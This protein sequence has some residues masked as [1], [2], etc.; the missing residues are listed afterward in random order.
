LS[1]FLVF[2]DLAASPKGKPVIWQVVEFGGR[3]PGDP[4]PRRIQGK[5]EE[6]KKIQ[7]ITK[8]MRK[9]AGFS[10]LHVHLL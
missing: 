6:K 3:I 9:I 10:W 5:I 7:H 8:L 1:L 4:N 2:G